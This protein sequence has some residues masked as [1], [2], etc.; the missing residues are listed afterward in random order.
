MSLKCRSSVALT[1]AK[2]DRSGLPTVLQGGQRC[3]VAYR[4]LMIMCVAAL[5]LV[6][7]LPCR[8]RQTQII[9]MMVFTN[10]LDP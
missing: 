7:G 9:L 2:A 4:R 10:F 6:T 5:N 3:F 1:V 8:H